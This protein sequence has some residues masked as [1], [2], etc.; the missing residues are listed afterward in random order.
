MINVMAGTV[1]YPLMN[2][3]VAIQAK[4]GNNA[5]YPMA[6][7]TNRTIPNYWIWHLTTPWMRM[8]ISSPASSYLRIPIIYTS[9]PDKDGSKMLP[10]PQNDLRF[11]TIATKLTKHEIDL[12]YYAG[13]WQDS[14]DCQPIPSNGTGLRNVLTNFPR[15]PLILPTSSLAVYPYQTC[16]RSGICSIGSNSS[17]AMTKVSTFDISFQHLQTMQGMK[18]IAKALLIKTCFFF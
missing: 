12:K 5:T 4:V 3:F 15:A 2:V 8:R 7:Y 6:Y 11:Q 9:S 17:S 18:I 14:G 16:V 13:H 1:H 10:S